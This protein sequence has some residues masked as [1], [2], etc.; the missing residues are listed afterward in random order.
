MPAKISPLP[1]VA[2]PRPVI[3]RERTGG[4]HVAALDPELR[5]ADRAREVFRRVRAGDDRVADLY[6]EDGVV[7]SGG[8]ARVEG[9]E[10]IRAFYRKTFAAIH[11]QPEVQVVLESP[12][13]NL[14]AVVVEV[15]TDTGHRHALDLFTID[16][17][18]IRRLEILN[19]PVD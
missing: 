12:G 13:S 11:P 17:E 9:R 8:G 4:V 10:T 2:D 15:A 18:G 6:A 1:T 3:L 16:D 7:L 5:G 14:Y 19:R